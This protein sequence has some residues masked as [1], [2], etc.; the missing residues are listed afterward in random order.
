MARGLQLYWLRE[1]EPQQAQAWDRF[2][3]AAAGGSFFHLAGWQRLLSGLYKHPTYYLY[4]QRDGQVVGVLPLARVRSRLFGDALISTPFCVYGGVVAQD[5]Q[6]QEAL[7]DEARWLTARLNVAHLELRSVTPLDDGWINKPL[8]ATF[9]KPIVAEPAA[10]L[11]EIP[12]KQRAEVRRGI[13]AGLVTRLLQNPDPC[14]RIYAES[15]RN[16]GTPVFARAHFQTLKQIFAERCEVAVVE[17]HGVA[18]SGVLSFYFRD[19][20]LPYYGGAL[21]HGRQVGAYPYMYYDLMN[22][23]AAQGCR[24]FDF[25]RSKRGTGAYDFKRFYGFSPQPLHYGYYLYERRELPDLNP[26]NP[27]Y[28]RFIALWRRLPLAVANGLGPLLARNLG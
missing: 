12:R 28:Q 24:W 26:L 13:Q 22:R 7:L 23:A 16:L 14:Y 8:Y 17:Q 9:R 1:D 6:V 25:G 5:L 18:V 19:Q 27:K 20:V 15:L 11:R 2:V 21:P 3:E 4:G 10:N